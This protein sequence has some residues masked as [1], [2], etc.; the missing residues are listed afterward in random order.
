MPASNASTAPEG[1]GGGGGAIVRGLAGAAEGLVLDEA[2]ALDGLEDLG[3]GFAFADLAPAD[4]VLPAI[5]AR[6]GFGLPNFFVSLDFG[7][8]AISEWQLITFGP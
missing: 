8:A 7:F 3:A 5:L 1:F 2:F 6:L 4:F